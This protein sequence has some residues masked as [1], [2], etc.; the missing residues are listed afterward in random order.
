MWMTILFIWCLLTSV[1]MIIDIINP[2]LLDTTP[3]WVQLIP[4]FVCCI[5]WGVFYHF[6]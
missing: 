4:Y 1:L 2:D 5:S 3:L 6:S